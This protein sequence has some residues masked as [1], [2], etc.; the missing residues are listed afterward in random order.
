M[1]RTDIRDRTARYHQIPRYFVGPA[2]QVGVLSANVFG[3]RCPV[4][5]RVWFGVWFRQWECRQPAQ[6]MAMTVTDFSHIVLPAYALAHARTGIVCAVICLR[7]WEAT[8]CTDIAFGA[9]RSLH[10]LSTR[11][12]CSGSIPKLSTVS[13]ALT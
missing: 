6:Y 8:S 11:P 3:M 1:A 9:V 4:L 13:D 5:N 10:R 12:K 7:A 2:H